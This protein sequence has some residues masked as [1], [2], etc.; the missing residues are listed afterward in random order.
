MPTCPVLP[1]L[2]AGERPTVAV[3]V[4]VTVP[5]K[6]RRTAAAALGVLLVAT[7]GVLLPAETAAADQ[8]HEA[9]FVA[10]INQSRA[11]AGLAALSVSGELTAVARSWSQVMA[12]DGDLRHNPHF[13][14]QVSSWRRV[15]E[16]VGRGPSV[17]S[18]HAGFMR[19]QGHRHNIL[20]GAVT[21]V[22]VGVVVDGG[23]VWVTQLFRQP[24]SPPKASTSP[25]SSSTAA[26]PSTTPSAPSVQQLREA[27][28][29]RAR[30]VEQARDDQSRLADLGWYTGAV[31]GIA[32]PVT[33]DAAARFQRAEGLTVDGVLG[34]ETR[35]ALAD[36]EAARF[37]PLA[38][39][40]GPAAD[41]LPAAETAVAENAADRDSTRRER[42]SEL[43]RA[44]R[45]H[46]AA[47]PQPH[48]ETAGT[49]GL[50]ELLTILDL[51]R[52]VGAGA[53]DAGAASESPSRLARL[54]VQL[55]SLWARLVG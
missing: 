10:A 45:D 9:S 48:R 16:N 38:P 49:A 22:G 20:D 25:G 21:Q 2:P 13:G 50:G 41:L 27:E 53:T 18:L 44:L 36:E 6:R 37:Q 11:E 40:R 4:P 52:P 19:S 15:T 8:G 47:S 39:R 7:F 32:G 46:D 42:A 34:P 51:D 1:A 17:S 31:D 35:K 26:A 24:S 54:R 23:V 33:R 30:K 5:R 28:Q 3:T 43:R 29:E 55:R 14:T 12:G